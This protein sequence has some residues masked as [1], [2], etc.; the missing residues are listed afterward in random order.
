[1]YSDGASKQQAN[2]SWANNSHTTNGRSMRLAAIIVIN[3]VIII[4]EVNS[5]ADFTARGPITETEQI[6]VNPLRMEL[7]P[8]AQ[9]CLTRFFTGDFAS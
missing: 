9:R 2:N 7:N 3:I 8:S 5:R 4:T 6:H 1:M